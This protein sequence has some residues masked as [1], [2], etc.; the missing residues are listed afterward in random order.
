[1]IR[2]SLETYRPRGCTA[3]VLKPL[4]GGPNGHANK[5]NARLCREEGE[6]GEG[7]EERG[8]ETARQRRL[9]STSRQGAD[10]QNLARQ[11]FRT[12]SGGSKRQ[13]REEKGRKKRG[14]QTI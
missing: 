7:E 13:K 12:E 4:L 6:E 2:N 10:S 8:S 9:A 5:S 1:M 14:R 3:I 11:S